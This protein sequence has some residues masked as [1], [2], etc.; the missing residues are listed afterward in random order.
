MANLLRQ[1]RIIG[2]PE[3]VSLTAFRNVD[4]RYSIQLWDNELGAAI[5]ISDTTLE[6]VL[7]DAGTALSTAIVDAAAGI[8]LVSLT[9]E[10]T[11]DDEVCPDSDYL[12]IVWIDSLGLR[13]PISRGPIEFRTLAGA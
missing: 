5:D 11:N 9:D 8:W 7:R 6:A 1:H 10:Q 4:F 12:T 3:L 13:H 2:D